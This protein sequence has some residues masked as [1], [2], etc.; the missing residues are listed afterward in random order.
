MILISVGTVLKAVPKV[1]PLGD[2]LIS[3]GTVLV[4]F[5]AEHKARKLDA[6]VDQL[7]E[8]MKKPEA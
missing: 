6:K 8:A 1:D 5:G 4:G 2:A 7:L 3:A